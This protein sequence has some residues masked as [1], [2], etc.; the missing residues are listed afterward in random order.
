M[1]AAE[2]R[3]YLELGS[4]HNSVNYPEVQL[5]E[6]EAVRVL[7]LHENIPNMISNITAAASKEGINIENMINKSKKDMSVTVM[8]MAELPSAHALNTL[9]ELPGIIR[10]RTF[11][12]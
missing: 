9:A 2:I 7:V 11:A 5:G 10:I 4:I 8:E 3:D 1:A 6:P 12:K